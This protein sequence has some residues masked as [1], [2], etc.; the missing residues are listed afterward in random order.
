MENQQ[1]RPRSI[2]LTS[3]QN[4]YLREL[5][6]S[7]KCS[8]GLSNR[9]RI[10]L[11]WSESR[12]VRKTA[13]DMEISTSTVQTWRQRWWDGVQQWDSTQKKWSDKDLRN[14]VMDLLTDEPR[15]GTPPKFSPEEVCEI[16]SVACI[17]P[18]ELGIPV[19][20]WSA[21][22]LRREV[23][24]QEIV[25]EISVRTVGRFLKRQTSSLSM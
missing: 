6:N 22:D 21:S 15:S 9:A 19:S 3:R 4:E 17:V 12:G 23:I 25:P 10:V 11:Y 7:R 2:L 20:H 16:I 14:K 18:K 13:R 8:R 1:S 24:K 5:S